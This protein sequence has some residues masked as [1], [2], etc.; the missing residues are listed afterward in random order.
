MGPRARLNVLTAQVCAAA[1][2]SPV[3]AFLKSPVVSDAPAIFKGLFVGDKCWKDVAGV[4]YGALTSDHKGETLFAFNKT[5]GTSPLN[6]IPDGPVMAHFKGINTGKTI[7]WG[8]Y[9]EQGGKPEMVG[10][11]SGD[12]SAGY[13]LE[14]KKE[15]VGTP[16]FINEFAVNPAAR[17]KGI[18]KVLTTLSVDKELGIT[19][20]LA[21]GDSKCGRAPIKCREM[22]TTFHIDNAASRA[23]FLKGGYREV[24][25][26]KDSLRE[27]NTTVAKWSLVD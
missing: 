10:L 5:H 16:F 13:W 20:L 9:M 18:G 4:T 21:A 3:D 24:V 12:E 27:R 23:S 11:I 2:K 17:G 25:T 6:Y 7:V 14:T 22:Y 15:E 26:Y 8:A 19:P 1:E